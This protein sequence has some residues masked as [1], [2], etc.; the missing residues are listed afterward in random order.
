M[1]ESKV[2]KD[3]SLIAEGFKLACDHLVPRL[4]SEVSQSL[5][6]H[7]NDMRQE[8]H[9]NEKQFQQQI[10][11]KVQQAFMQV[12]Q[13]MEEKMQ[14]EMKGMR[15]EMKEMQQKLEK[16]VQRQLAGRTFQDGSPKLDGVITP[17]IMRLAANDWSEGKVCPFGRLLLD[18]TDAKVENIIAGKSTPDEKTY[19]ILE[20]WYNQDGRNA[21]VGK[22]LEVCNDPVIGMGGAVEMAL[23]RAGLI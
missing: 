1:K 8:T 7:C 4:V 18:V 11:Q 9:R 15:Q 19:A 21:T 10:E 22:L 12:R 3:E 17:Q 16:E 13:E 20:A 5:L 14:Q 2:Q 6:A 23:K